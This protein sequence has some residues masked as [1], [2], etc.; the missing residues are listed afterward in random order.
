MVLVRQWTRLLANG[1]LPRAFAVR[2]KDG[3]GQPVRLI[4]TK[5]SKTIHSPLSDV[6]IPSDIIYE[7]VWKN[8]EKWPDHDA[9]V[10]GLTN[11]KYTY[12]QARLACKRFATTLR[13]RGV[14]E[15]QV[16]AI[17]LP[18]IPEFGICSLGFNEAGI[19]V[20]T[21][22]PLYTSYEMA[23]QLKDS[24]AV[25]IVTTPELLSR[26]IKAEHMIAEP[27]KK[28]IINICINISGSRVEEAWDFFEMIDSSVDTSSK[29]SNHRLSEDV[30]FMPYSSGT[31]GLSKGVA[32]SNKNLAININQLKH[33]EIKHIIN[34]SADHQDV[35]PA[36]LPFYHIYGLTAIMLRGLHE[37]CKIVSLPKLESELFLSILKDH[38]A[39]ILYVVPPLILLLGHNKNITPSHFETLRLICNGAGPV[40][41]ADGEKVLAR[42]KNKNLRFLQAYGMTETSPVVFVTRNSDRFSYLTVGPPVSNTMARIVDP[43]DYSILY[44]PN[45]SGEIQVKGPQVMLGYH[46]NPKA[47]ANTIDSNGWLSTGDIGYYD[48]KD[49]FYISDRLKE[50]IKV[51]GY[52][53][54]P[55]EL[56]GIL[57]T[58]PSITD[59]AVVGIP[60]PKTGEVP[61]AFVVVDPDAASPSTEEVQ[62][63]VSKQVSPYKQITGGVKFVDSL[64]KSAAGKILRRLLKEEYMKN[65]Q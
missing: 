31:T 46:N 12:H 32:L 60:H 54:P 55:A 8:L 10:C 1:C 28:P 51:Q 7:F 64:P 6:E 33:P 27:N 61:L 49:N 3:R 48:E 16:F 29:I 62:N 11:R 17:I 4:H 2:L 57:R 37:G 59:A 26:V 47:T 20:T 30:A 41:E 36:I 19:V 24:G 40:K 50:L 21:M 56:E 22:N 9:L 13:R 25:G 35:I 14:S 18:N 63:F 65:Q 15:G 43:N 23:H 45:E 5:E 42:S 52:Q 34:T 38:K 39:T 44:G 58:H 53:V